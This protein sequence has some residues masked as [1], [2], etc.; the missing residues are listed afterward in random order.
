MWPDTAT[1]S[2]NH[3][4]KQSQLDV[5]QRHAPEDDLDA[6]CRGPGA[7][8]SLR[9]KDQYVDQAGH[10]GQDREGRSASVV[11]KALPRNSNLARADAAATPNTRFI[12]TAIAAVMSVRRIALQASG[13]LA[14]TAPRVMATYRLTFG[15][16]LI[17]ALVNLVLGLLVARDCLRVGLLS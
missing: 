4:V 16:S 8:P 13:S 17:A 10:H 1:N 2:S 12:G 9:S 14:V 7:E 5:G 15:A 3:A 6:V 11:K